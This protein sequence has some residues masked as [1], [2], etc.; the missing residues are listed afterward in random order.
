MSRIDDADAGTGNAT[1]RP[2]RLSGSSESVRDLGLHDHVCW[3]Y[4]DHADFLGLMTDFLGDGLARGQ[5]VAYVAG[6]DTTSLWGHLAPLPGLGA[7]IAAD[8]VRVISTDH[9]YAEHPLDPHDQVATYASA[10]SE[11]IAD[12]FSGLRVAAE[13]TS[14]MSSRAH[15]DAFARYEFLID[16]FMVD[17]PFA[18]MCAHDRTGVDPAWSA[19]MMCMHP[20]SGPESPSFQLFA[21]SGSD[22]EI[23]GEIDFHSI[24]LL[25]RSLRRVPGPASS[26]WTLDVGGLG[27]CDHRMMEAL[28]RFAV[29]RAVRVEL[30]EATHHHATLV[31]LTGCRR[32]EVAG[33]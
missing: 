6:G 8:S 12:G 22:G 31:D 14:L 15:I 9:V 21:G 32:V 27:F 30:L 11:A 23:R 25:D 33:R 4:E 10:T 20:L 29:E 3:A 24:D 1:D 13:V 26:T 28:E 7:L 5:R 17:R 18:A 16:Q 2:T 19:E